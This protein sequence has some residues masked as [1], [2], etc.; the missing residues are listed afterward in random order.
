MI[1]DLVQSRRTSSLLKTSVAF[2]AWI[3]LL[4]SANA[5]SYSELWGKNGEHWTPQSRLPDFSHAGYQGGG[6]TLPDVPART[7]VKD[8]GARGDGV[9]DDSPAFAAALAAT[10][11]GAVVVPPGRYMLTDKIR[12]TKSRVVLRGAG[13]DH[14]VLVIPKSLQQLFPLEN[15]SFGGEEK[16]RYSFGEAFVEANGDDNTEP[17]G[18]V[19]EP[20]RRGDIQLACAR[21]RDIPVGSLI[22]L[23][24]QVERELGRHL[25]ADMV[26][27]GADTLKSSP[28]LK[29]NARVIAVSGERLTLDRPLR[30]DVRPE[31]QATLHYY[32]PSVQEVGVEGFSFEFAGPP[33]KKHLLEEGFN[34]IHFTKVANGWVRNV[35]I[36]DADLGV[37]MS[38]SFQCQVENVR[39]LADKR[40]GI[41]G[42][43]ALWASGNSQD[44]LFQDFELTTTYL[45]DI[46]LEGYANG[47]VFR[48]GRAVRLTLDLHRNGPFENLFTNIDAG[49]PAALWRSSGRKDRGPHSGARTTAWNLRHDGGVVYAP[50]APEREFPQINLIGVPGIEAAKTDGQWS[51]PLADLLPV[52]LYVAQLERRLKSK[53][54]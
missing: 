27:A 30:L 12:I 3:L 22:Q 5:Q 31:W 19:A 25:H 4:C 41:T 39:M 9:T 29:W 52:D 50:H 37:K 42:H 26:N 34:A 6:R 23:R 53:K 44:C 7:N 1:T 48:Q 17:I 11:N 16:N 45:H 15:Y 32:R 2:V 38:G 20:A 47:N 33:K 10:E 43:H 40:S 28:L 8:F 54:D 18:P 46:S 24:M 51:E 21:A 14:T 35:R 36:I 49:N 13:P